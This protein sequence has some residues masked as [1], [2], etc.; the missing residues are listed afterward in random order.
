MIPTDLTYGFEQNK[1]KFILQ[2]NFWELFSEIN[3][4]HYN[5]GISILDNNFAE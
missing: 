5:L 4:K 1:S 2:N 3:L